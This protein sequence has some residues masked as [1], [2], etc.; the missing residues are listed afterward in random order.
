MGL[1]E[2]EAATS[3]SGVD[4]RDLETLSLSEVDCCCC[5]GSAFFAGCFPF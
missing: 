5:C 3:D 2:E 1:D 4:E